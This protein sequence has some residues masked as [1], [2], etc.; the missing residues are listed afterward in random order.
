ML[1]RLDEDR[2]INAIPKLLP[3]DQQDR[4]RTLRAVQ[5]VILAKGE[6]TP[7]GKSRL[8]KVEHLF[9]VKAASKTPGT[10]KEESDVSA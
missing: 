4:A 9:A 10:V 8:A 3:R 2:A 5:R 1:V 6:L 7:E